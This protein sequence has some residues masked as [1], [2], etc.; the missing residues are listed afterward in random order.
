MIQVFSPLFRHRTIVLVSTIVLGLGSCVNIKNEILKNETL[1]S[2]SEI[3]AGELRL[4]ELRV[5]TTFLPITQFTQAVAG[6]R[7]T[8][9]LPELWEAMPTAS[10]TRG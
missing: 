6:D 10:S 8:I 2:E 7:V 5:V 9:V 4:G 3:Q 1:K